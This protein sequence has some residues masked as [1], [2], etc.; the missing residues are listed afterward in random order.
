MLPLNSVVAETLLHRLLIGWLLEQLHHLD[1]LGDPG[2]L[3]VLHGVVG[4]TRTHP[5]A[6]GDIG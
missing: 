3:E 5:E 1:T 2:V 6:G 4:V